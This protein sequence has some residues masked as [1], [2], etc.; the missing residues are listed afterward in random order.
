MARA[1]RP[2]RADAEQSV[3]RILEAAERVLAQDPGA[4][5]EHVAQE[6]G[7]ARTTVHRRFSSREE[8][9]DALVAVVNGRLREALEAARADVAPPLAALYQL[10]VATFELKADWH[11]A[12]ELTG[13]GSAAD[14][15][16]DPAV[17]DGLDRLL[18]RAQ[19][20]GLLRRDSDLAWTRR[21]YL[22]L[23]HEATATGPIDSSASRRA[24][25]VLETLL[26][27]VGSQDLD[28]ANLLGT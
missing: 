20:S 1:R 22:A 7:V 2:L 4:S 6:A 16:I 14:S 24:G 3:V 28:L 12:M 10:T 13:D 15:A 17:L 18:A 8:L 26:R 5:L 25:L 23:M 21:V 9:M 11:F 27:G 19:G